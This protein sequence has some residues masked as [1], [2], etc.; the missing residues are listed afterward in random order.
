MTSLR[1]VFLP[2]CGLALLGC[3]APTAPPQEK[4]AAKE[5]PQADARGSNEEPAAASEPKSAEPFVLGDL[6]PKF[7]PP[8]LA[9]LEAKVKWVDS[10]VVDTLALLR[11]QKEK[12][13]AKVSVE[14]ALKL[15]NDSPEANEK[16]LSALSV[17]A[18]EDGQGVNYDATISR[19]LSMDIGK[20]NPLRSSSISE[21]EILGLTSFGVFSFDWEMNPLAS[22]DSVVSWQTSE[23]HMYDK[24]VL[25]DD[26]TWSDGKPITA[27]D[28]EFSYRVI[29]SSK[30]PIEA[31]RTGTDELLAV[32][33]YDDHTLVYFH[34]NPFATN[35]WNLN[36]AV[37]P[38]H[39]YEQTIAADPTL[40]E[41]EEHA[42]L[43]L[44][45]V[46]GG[47]YEIARWR[48]GQEIVLTRRESAYMHNGKQVR[49]KPYFKEIR[50]RIL[51]DESTSLLALKSGQIE[52]SVLGAEQ[53]QTQTTGTDFY[54]Q[55]T[56][57]MG[58][59]WTYFHIGWNMDPKACPF[60]TDKRVRQALAYAMNYDEMVNDLCFGLFPQSQ[61]IWHPDSWMFP[62]NPAPMFTYDL[63]KAEDLLDEA[64]WVDSDGDGVR[65]KEINGEVVPFEFTIIVGNKP[66][67]VAICN[68]FRES[69][70]S[71]GINCQ[72]SPMEA[73][74]LMQRMFNK[75]FQAN[76][77]GWG[78]GTDPDLSKNVYRTGESRNYGSY[79]NPEVDRLYAEGQKEFD[80]AKRAE[81]YGQIHNLIYEDQPSLYLYNRSSFYGFNKKLRGYRLSPRG[82]F[83]FGPGFSAIWAPVQ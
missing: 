38:K 14:E 58:P 56:K 54:N 47:A 6:A 40:V 22:S 42:A 65:D 8:T 69:L 60:F 24:V 59:E 16:I 25:R 82:P 41:S 12:E 27:H 74:V 80:R 3:G 62:K 75:E 68:L 70:E 21:A 63:D 77:A 52:E 36:F 73:A 13:P 57:I 78:T 44:K 79:S 64:G 17:L 19:A 48:R 83:H 23:D 43:E 45:P 26:L 7:D 55:N 51:E 20:T 53:W 32:K 29:M 49:D 39:K 2:L 28:V 71:I 15:E 10:P 35:V 72:I 76:M 5:A 11:K 61:G 4:P 9:E 81:I 34:K 31:M 66:D 67:R 46:T 50:F 37:I 33:A 18:P 30:V 1:F